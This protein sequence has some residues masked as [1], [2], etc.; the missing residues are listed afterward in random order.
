MQYLEVKYTVAKRIKCKM[1]FTKK[2]SKLIINQHSF[3]FNS[4]YSIAIC[5]WIRICLSWFAPSLNVP[6]SVSTR[7]VVSLVSVA[8]LRE[9]ET[10]VW[11]WIIFSDILKKWVMLLVM[12]W[13]QLVFSSHKSLFSWCSSYR[14]LFFQRQSFHL[15]MRLQCKKNCFHLSF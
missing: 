6:S 3:F 15:L 2:C 7:A 13:L 11:Q 14:V 5:Q 9:A 12:K 4:T 10:I 8:V 1:V